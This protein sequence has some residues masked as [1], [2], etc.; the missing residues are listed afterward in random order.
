MRNAL[1]LQYWFSEKDDSEYVLNSMNL[2][3]LIYKI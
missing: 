3:F 1:T 2:S